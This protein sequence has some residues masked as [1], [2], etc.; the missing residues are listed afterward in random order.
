MPKLVAVIVTYNSSAMIAKLLD[1]LLT[2]SRRLDAI[3]VVDNHSQDD[4]CQIIQS[5]CQDS[6]ILH[7]LSKNLGGAGGYAHGLEFARKL[8]ADY[9]FTFDDDSYPADHNYLVK[10]LQAQQ[11][12]HWDVTC[13]VVVD[14]TDHTKTAYI[15]RYQNREFISVKEIQNIKFIENDIKLFN[16]VLFQRNVLELLQG[17]N[18]KLFIRGDEQEFRIR[19]LD[20]GFKVGVCTSCLI[21]HPSSLHEYQ[22]LGSRR[23]HHIDSPFKLFFS[24]RNRIY[25]LK[26]RQKFS[27]RKKTVLIGKELYYYTWFYMV[28]RHGDFENYAVWLKAFG[29]GL[30]GYMNNHTGKR[31]LV[32]KQ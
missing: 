19:I 15:Y 11:V 2:Q 27:L 5:Y 25:L 30:T 28:H 17:P 20:T 21:Y 26:N 8:H 6:I 24:T 4:T 9:I 12:Y 31:Y 29:C 3:I 13:P 1:N 23:F 10:M 18:P 22:T 14:S 32:K 16:G 7:R